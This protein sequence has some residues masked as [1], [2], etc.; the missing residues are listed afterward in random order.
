MSRALMGD[1]VSRDWL[2]SEFVREGN[3]DGLRTLA[4]AMGNT[5]RPREELARLLAERGDTAELRSRA[6]AG[7]PHAR[8]R[9]V[10][11]LADRGD[12][13]QLV[14][15]AKDG[16]ALA[17]AMLTEG[18]WRDGLRDLADSE[19][20]VGGLLYAAALADHG[21]V[22]ELQA[23]AE[24][25]DSAAQEVLDVIA[26]RGTPQHLAA[27]QHDADVGNPMAREAVAEILVQQ[28]RL[29]D[30]RARAMQGDL[31]AQRHLTA[32]LAR[33][34]TQDSVNELQECVHAA[35]DGAATRLLSIYRSESGATVLDL[36][37]NAQPVTSATH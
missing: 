23:R 33:L 22:E 2:T 13:A 21:D 12:T 5:D 9:L 27:L 26:S 32:E 35:Y 18:D 8:R 30:L 37:V 7:D 20:S 29:A 11:L 31:P 14:A 34:R 4:G 6:D 16:D 28:G 36:D 15:R 24:D 3:L 19:P 1:V 17:E 25:G 10:E